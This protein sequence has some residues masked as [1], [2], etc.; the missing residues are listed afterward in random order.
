MTT[1]AVVGMGAMGSG[2]AARLALNGADIVTDLDGRSEATIE[3]AARIGARS[4]SRAEMIRSADLIL[5]IIPPGKAVETAR[6]LAQEMGGANDRPLFVDCNAI[7]PQTM[8]E[9]ET[10]FSTSHLSC[11]DGSIIGAPPKQEGPGP[12]LYLSGPVAEAASLLKAHGID[13]RVLSDRIGDASALKMSYAGITKGFQALGSAMALG[14]ARNGAAQSFLD[15]LQASQ[16]QL[17]AWLSRQLPIMYDKAY[18]W[19][20]E[21]REIAKFLA[22]EAGSVGMLTGAADLYRHIA[23]DNAEGPHSQIISTL[24]RFVGASA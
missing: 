21:M 23:A 6:L 5:S 16:P 24:N 2:I 14:A 3:R 20:N 12:R 11:A 10:I 17:Y 7:A 19:D 15:E 9:I 18:R 8:A 1:I 22:P 13:A 4:V